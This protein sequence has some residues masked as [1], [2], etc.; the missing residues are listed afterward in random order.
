MT[1]L[2]LG[3][4]MTAAELALWMGHDGLTAAERE[5]EAQRARSRRN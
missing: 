3:E 1:V 5:H 2:E 4:R